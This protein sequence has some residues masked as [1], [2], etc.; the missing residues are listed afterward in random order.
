MVGCLAK[1]PV[2]RKTQQ[3]LN[4]LTGHTKHLQQKERQAVNYSFNSIQE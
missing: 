1:L 3:E 4:S 2:I